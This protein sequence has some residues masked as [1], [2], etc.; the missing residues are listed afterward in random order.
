MLKATLVQN[1][2][3]RSDQQSCF[4]SRFKK[5]IRGIFEVTG[6]ASDLENLPL[7]LFQRGE[8]VT[9]RGADTAIDDDIE[10]HLVLSSHMNIT[11]LVTDTGLEMGES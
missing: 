1:T 11:D 7:P 9:D 10:L 3:G 2:F 8:L 5:G 4:T 6:T